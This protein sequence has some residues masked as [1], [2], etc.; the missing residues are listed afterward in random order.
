MWQADLRGVMAVGLNFSAADLQ[1]SAFT[2]TFD[3]GAAIQIRPS[4]TLQVAGVV[5]S[6]VYLWQ[7]HDGQ[8]ADEV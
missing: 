5:K 2:L 6:D 7:A 4:G 8:L 3:T 1:R